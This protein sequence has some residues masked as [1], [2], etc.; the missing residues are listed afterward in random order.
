M[1]ATCWL[2]VC[3]L[4]MIGCTRMTVLPPATPL[5]VEPDPASTPEVRRFMLELRMLAAIDSQRVAWQEDER[6]EHYMDY[7][8]PPLVRE[9]LTF[10]SRMLHCHFD[11]SYPSGS[12]RAARAPGEP[13]ERMP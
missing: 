13:P 1:R 8:L 7:I 6:L 11:G 12:P 5:P 10:R 4:L 9:V 3:A 2:F